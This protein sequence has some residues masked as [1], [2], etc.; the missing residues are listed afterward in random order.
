MYGKLE[1]LQAT[2]L[3]LKDYIA[4]GIKSHELKNVILYNAATTVSNSLRTMIVLRRD[5]V[6]RCRAIEVQFTLIPVT[7]LA[8]NLSVFGKC[9]AC[10]YKA[11]LLF[12]RHTRVPLQLLTPLSYTELYLSLLSP[13]A[14]PLLRLLSIAISRV[15]PYSY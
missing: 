13:R 14:A 12:S 10:E 3:C 8:R 11:Q 15:Y 7:R 1:I 4:E 9:R 2:K 6:W 5:C